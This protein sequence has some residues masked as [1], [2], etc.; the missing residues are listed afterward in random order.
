[1]NNQIKS[2][3]DKSPAKSSPSFA[4]V[5]LMMLCLISTCSIRKGLQ[6]FFS[7]NTIEF[8]GSGKLNKANIYNRNVEFSNASCNTGSDIQLGTQPTSLQESLRVAIIP[9][10]FFVL[11]GFLLSLRSLVKDHS[12]LPIP[13]SL[14]RWPQTA[15]FLQNRLLLI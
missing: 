12:V 9:F 10:L 5:L 3:F 13:L 7:Q 4:V 11:P 8:T 1:M 6:S 2:F 15:L 14:L